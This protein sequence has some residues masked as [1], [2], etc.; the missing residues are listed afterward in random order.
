MLAREEFECENMGLA[1]T[2]SVLGKFESRDVL[3]EKKGWLIGHIQR[4]FIVPTQRK[5]HVLLK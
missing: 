4:E 3:C 2:C 1:V 5:N